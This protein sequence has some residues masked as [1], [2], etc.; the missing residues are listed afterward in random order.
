DNLNGDDASDGRSAEA[1]SSVAGPVRSIGRG[2]A[3]ARRG[4]TIVIANN[5]KPYRES[6]QITGHRLSGFAGTDMTV[7]G[8]G[9]VVTGERAVPPAAWKK[10]DN[11]LWKLVPQRKGFYLLLREGE[12]VVEVDCPNDATRLPNLGAGEWC[13]WRGAIHYRSPELEDPRETNFSLAARGVGLT[14][15]NVRGVTV[16]DLTFQHFR[17]DGV[18]AHDLSH[19]VTLVNVRTQANGRAGVAVAGTSRLTLEK[20]TIKD[21]RVHSVLVSGHGEAD[22]LETTINQPVTV[23]D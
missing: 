12:R 7:L 4:D 14:L 3:L 2:L 23:A 22:L 11:D 10:L 18:N 6:I 17:L 19:N 20:C 1:S 8:N 16:R 5:G 21:N 9:A 15:H 13:V